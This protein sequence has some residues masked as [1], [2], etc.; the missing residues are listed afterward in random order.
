MKRVILALVAAIFATIGLSAAAVAQ[1]SSPSLGDYA[2]SV[3]QTKSQDAKT[4]AKVYDNDNLPSATISV[5]GGASKSVAQPGNDNGSG[6][7]SNNGSSAS[8]QNA[9]KSAD[10]KEKVSPGQ[11]LQDR[12][13]VFD[14]WKSRIDDQKKKIDQLAHDLDNYQHNSTMAQVSVWPQT[15]RYGEKLAEKQKALDQAKAQLSDLQEQARKA[16]VPASVSE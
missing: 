16:G 2:R 15:Q 13:K 12:Q 6:V 5:V 7:Q 4:P 1:T 3:R 14:A 10:Q 8:D 9:D 11:S